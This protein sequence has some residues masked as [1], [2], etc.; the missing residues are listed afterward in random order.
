MKKI[1]ITLTVITL[2]IQLS[3]IIAIVYLNLNLVSLENATNF[4]INKTS[5]ELQNQISNNQQRTDDKLLDL[6]NN[7]ISTQSTFTNQINALKADTRS[8]FSGIIPT[9]L[10]G[11]VSIS[12]DIAQ[13]S[14][15][16]ISPE[17]YIITNA[18]VLVG[19]RYA[20]V[21]LYEDNKWTP[22]KLIGYDSIMDIAILKIENSN[23]YLEFENSNN[24]KIGEK[25]IALGNPLGL[26]FSVSEGIISAKDRKGPNNF[27][28]Y[29]QVD[30]PLNPGNSGGPLVNKE[31]KV[32][33]I[34]N[35]KLQNSENL[36]F[37]LE[38]NYAIES[39]NKI[40]EENNQT[41]RVNI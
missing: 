19:G 31:G 16:I 11:V 35:F 17:G 30:V 2:I 10:K 38:S 26:S 32:V 18:H 23:N 4:K 28:S 29:F 34:N 36:G 27:E 39:I 14:G 21:L 22:A 40:L 41:I 13:G 1:H 33:G 9:V 37:S 7:L 12:T 24:V 25:V 5:Y 15:F 3:T 8:D 20:R 6:S